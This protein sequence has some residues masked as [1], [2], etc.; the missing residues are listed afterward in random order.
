MQADGMLGDVRVPAHS[1]RAQPWSPAMAFLRWIS[2]DPLS[3]EML[4]WLAGG[5]SVFRPRRDTAQ[6]EE[7]E[8]VVRLLREMRLKELVTF[9]D[10]HLSTTAGGA[11]LAVGPVLITPRGMA[12]L[13]RDRHLGER[14]SYGRLPWQAD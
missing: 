14:P 3:F 13:E 9:L 4:A 7:F 2:L 11:Y 10:G 12:L 6:P 8:E 1:V 5:G